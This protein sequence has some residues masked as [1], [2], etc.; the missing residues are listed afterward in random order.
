MAKN[1]Y[2]NLVHASFILVCSIIFS[3]FEHTRQKR[4]VQD[5]LKVLN[6]RPFT[7]N[8]Y[9]MWENQWNPTAYAVREQCISS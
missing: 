8:S 3:N 2:D 4:I 6:S 5:H 1:T 7:P 9:N